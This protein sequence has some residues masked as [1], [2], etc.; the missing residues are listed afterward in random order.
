MTKSLIERAVAG[1]GPKTIHDRLTDEQRESLPYQWPLWARPQ[2]LPP[3]GKWRVWLFLAGR[4]A[5][6]TR[7]AA[8]WVRS[9]AES[10][11][12]R[13]IA[14]V[15]QTASD[16]RDVMVEGGPSS[17]MK[18]SRPDFRPK[19]EP[20][21]CRLTWPNG[22]TATTYS[23]DDPGQLRG[24]QFDAAWC[25]ELAKWRRDRETWD[26][27]MLGLRLSAPGGGHPR[28][29]VT[30]TPRPSSLIIELARGLRTHDGSRK[31]RQDIAVTTGSTRDNAA[32][33]APSFLDE[34]M[35]LYGGTRLGRQELDA[36]ILEDIEGALWGLES[37]EP[38]RLAA[39]D[40]PDLEGLVVAIDPATTSREDSDETGIVVAGSADCDFYVLDDLS[41]KASP[42]AWASTA[43]AAYRDYHA[44]Y[45]VA[46]SNQG[47]EMVTHTLRSIDSGVPIKLVH[48]SRGK[49]IRAEPVA[50]LYEQGR[51]H[52]IGG[53]PRLEDQMCSWVPGTKSPD[54]LDALVWAITMLSAGS[55]RPARA[56]MRVI[57]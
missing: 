44:D 3:P 6:K 25:D 28:C 38:H 10:R 27:L 33:L 31:P 8:E 13:H 50:S 35:R 7:A 34:I 21:K 54:R 24:P 1:F 16:A 39:E 15:A 56:R 52:H 36:E 53:F 22:V 42:M 12:A 40:V 47:G 20:S 2:Q 57:G 48:A 45:I 30:T 49:R 51:V 18:I 55:R 46:E 5:G 29:I 43:I 9:L 19:Y 14:L 4:G 17:I 32:N 11:T 37:I 26:N 41:R 23:A